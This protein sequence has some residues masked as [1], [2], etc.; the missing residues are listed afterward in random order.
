MLKTA[1]EESR[2]RKTPYEVALIRHAN[3][4]ST[5][6]HTAVMRAVKSARSEQ[7]LE[8]I[9]LKTCIERGCR[10]QAYHGIFAAGTSA[11][12]LH[13]VR[14][15]APLAGKLNLLLD[16]GA[17][18]RCYAS[19]IT[20]TFPVGGRFSS[21]SRAIYDVVLRMQEECLAMLKEGVLWDSVHEHAHRVAIDGLRALG[22]LKG[23]REEILKARTSVAFFPHGLGHYMGMDTHDTG[24]NPDYGDSD[25]MFRYLRVRGSLPRDSVIT[26]EPGIYFCRFI[27]EPYLRDEKHR[28]F[29]DEKVLESYWEVG[30]VR[31][32]G[33]LPVLDARLMGSEACVNMGRCAN[34]YVRRRADHGG[35]VR[36]SNTYAEGGGGDG[37][38][39]QWRGCL[40]GVLEPWMANGGPVKKA[41]ELS[42][43]SHRT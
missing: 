6:A 25:T 8:A 23:D 12:T 15:D 29:I 41:W 31:I 3:A 33:M 9:F 35:R 19:D 20:R 24:G 21:E 14:N 26:V 34:L 18:A 22:V 28:G 40:S 39:D 16:A 13:Y 5:A 43:E 42:S 27:V 32:E 4:V 37:E 17:E 2:V 38:A 7:E 1:I 36:E 11:A 30:G 10:N